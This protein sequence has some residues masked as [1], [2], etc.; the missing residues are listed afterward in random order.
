MRVRSG[1][2]LIL[3]TAFFTLVSSPVSAQEGDVCDQPN[4]LSANC[5][6]MGKYRALP[7]YGSLR[8][9]WSPFV[10]GRAPDFGGVDHNAYG[11][12]GEGDQHIWTDGVPWTAGVY[13]VVNNT[14]PGNGYRAEIGWFVSG[15]KL[16][17][18]TRIGIDPTGGTDPNSPNIVWSPLLVQD[19]AHR[20]VRATAA[21]SSM[22][23]WAY[24]TIQQVTGDDQ[25]WLTAFALM[26]D[27]SVPTAAPTAVVPP[28]ATAR[29][30]PTNTRPP[31]PRPST[32]TQ[33]ATAVPT[34]TSLATATETATASST[35]NPTET[36]TETE[37]PQP[38]TITRRA[39]AT[40]TPPAAVEAVAGTDILAMGLVGASG[41]SLLFALGMGVF[42]FWFW[43]RK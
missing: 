1:L 25:V 23:I 40:A 6:F 42:A 34:A 26:S 12:P 17:A 21:N 20:Q 5:R 19:K 14:V 15:N 8:A 10:I 28:T 4:I 11:V 31:P 33:T 9:A 18:K 32:P 13:Q 41:C 37:A 39:T 35:P 3:I 30:L 16:Y 36:A 7:G 22:S 38:A 2:L 29:P 24:A 43:R 27:A